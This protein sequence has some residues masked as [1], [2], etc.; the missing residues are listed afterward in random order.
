VNVTLLVLVVAAGLK[1]AVTP[2]GMPDT[3]S[4]TLPLKPF[5]AF[6]VTVAAPVLAGVMVS[7]A[8]EVDSRKEGSPVL[9]VKSLMRC[10]PA[11]EPHPAVRSYP[12]TAEN[13]PL[14]PLVMSFMSAA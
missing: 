14:L 2:L 12:V 5:V 13:P 10:C 9:P 4:P 11:G 7:A 6:T 1:A 3:A 8:A